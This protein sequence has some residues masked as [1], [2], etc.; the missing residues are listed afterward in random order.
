MIPKFIA[1]GFGSGYLPAMPGTWGS[2]VGVVIGFLLLQFAGLA[3]LTIGFFVSFFLG[4]ILSQY[5]VNQ[6]PDDLDPSYIVIDEIAGIL[7]CFVFVLSWSHMLVLDDIL[8]LFF[9]FRVFDII[10]P[11][12]INQ[13]ERSCADSPKTAGFGIMID[14]ILAA[15]YTIIV[16][17]LYKQLFY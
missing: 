12:P 17:L 3:G 16:Y 2:I 4:W 10:K 13:I 1:S 7:F 9:V 5:L 6:E 8:L 15:I 14:D 11:F